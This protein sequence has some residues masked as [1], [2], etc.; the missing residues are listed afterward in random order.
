MPQNSPNTSQP[1]ANSLSTSIPP[2]SG[3]PSSNGM[4]TYLGTS[5]SPANLQPGQQYLAV[6]SWGQRTVP[7]TPP[8]SGGGWVF[9]GGSVPPANIQPGQQY[10]AVDSWSR[11]NGASGSS[12]STDIP[13]S[14]G[15]PD[16]SGLWTYLGT[17][18]PPA[19]LQPGQ[20]YLA[21]ESWAQRTAPLSS[22][23]GDGWIFDGGSVAPANLQPGQQY[24]SVDSWE[25]PL[26][27]GDPIA[28]GATG[29]ASSSAFPT[30]AV[31][32]IVGVA[33]LAT[34]LALLFGGGS[35]KGV[36]TFN[37]KVSASEQNTQIASVSNETSASIAGHNLLDPSAPVEQTL[38]VG[39]DSSSNSLDIAGSQSVADLKSQQG[40]HILVENGGGNTPDRL[41]RVTALH[42]NGDTKIQVVSV[43]KNQRLSFTGSP[44]SYTPMFNQ[45]G[46]ANE[47]GIEA[48][49]S[50]RDYARISQADPSWAPTLLQ[51][52]G[53]SNKS[54]T[55][56]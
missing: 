46:S 48:V 20:Q 1:P 43:A 32:A 7:N 49:N 56:H 27:S 6:E 31:G 23:P 12:L 34:I 50:Q 38:S 55:P 21:M 28:S 51:L 15:P 8:P 18:Q 26:S 35:N 30:I 4:W 5:Q 19:N 11:P 2:K 33:A 40:S 13:P 17:S 16:S 45:D 3:P 37:N 39:N 14:Y 36:Q 42:E 24:L 10:L 22:S 53:A 47:Q 29:A 52:A 54:V 9:D 41:V 25:K 44:T